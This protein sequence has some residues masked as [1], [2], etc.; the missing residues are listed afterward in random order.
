MGSRVPTRFGARTN[1]GLLLL[2]LG[3]FLTGWLAFAYATAP[4]RWSLVVHATSGIAIL[5]LLPWKSMIARRGMSR[6][7]P[8]RWASILL[9]LLVITSLLAGLA[10]STGLLVYAG[11]FSA[12]EV[13]VGAALAAV[14]FVVWHVAVRRIRIRGTDVSRRNFLR[15]AVVISTA[16]VAYGAGELVVR[17]TGLPGA[18][19]RFTGSYEAGS[20]A[21]GLMPVSS[22][23]FDSIPQ[24][25]AKDWRL[26]IGDRA[27]S[28]EELAA[29]DDR[30]VAT[31]DC[32]G[33][34]YSTQVWSGARLDRLVKDMRGASIRVVSHSGY[35]R[36]FPID[37]AVSLLLATRFGDQPLD[38]G[39]GFPARLVAPGRRGFW[40]VKWVTAIEVDDLPYWW[41]SPFPTQ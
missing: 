40:W 19:R 35:D 24:V 2:L 21:P 31:L 36:R 1:L 6:N 20:Y 28:Y 12:M 15:G 32:T 34:F 14:P 29:F 8:H 22:W 27:L 30:V 25:E 38:A 4:A 37:Q 26:R 10:H 18:A 39:H 5:L 16:A 33:G 41:Q 17:A 23:M 7:R 13:H 9:G 11:P 3:A